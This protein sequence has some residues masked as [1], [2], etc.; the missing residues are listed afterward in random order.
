MPV[1]YLRLWARDLA[2]R[3]EADV[4][5]PTRREISQ[6]LAGVA[7]HIDAFG[8][9][10]HPLGCLYLELFRD[11]SHSVRFHFWFPVPEGPEIVHSHDFDMSSVVLTGSLVNSVYELAAGAGAIPLL[12]IEYTDAGE[13]LKPSGVQVACSRVTSQTLFPDQGYCVR[14]GQFHSVR[15]QGSLPV[16]TFVSTRRVASCIGQVL[17][18]PGRNKSAA[19]RRPCSR[20]EKLAALRP[21]IGGAPDIPPKPDLPARGGA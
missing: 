21:L 8:A 3:F 15:P 14:A 5:A 18:Y 17:A 10:W 12:D 1:R 9:V 13:I 11:A 16:A 2:A 7:E 6:L 20:E 4:G 19:M